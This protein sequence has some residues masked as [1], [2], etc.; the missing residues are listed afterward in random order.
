MK[1]AV[2]TMQK[3]SAFSIVLLLLVGCAPIREGTPSVMIYKQIRFGELS[4]WMKPSV[5]SVSIEKVG[6][7]ESVYTPS[8]DATSI[9]IRLGDYRAKLICLR[10]QGD[11]LTG[12]ILKSASRSNADGFF[13]FSAKSFID[14]KYEVNESY[15]Q[16]DCA[17]SPDGTPNFSFDPIIEITGE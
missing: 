12:N 13:Y 8:V 4:E 16:L 10:P 14:P 9:W 6:D 5:Q 2:T 15:F 1:M 3:L 11:R 17:V 7:P